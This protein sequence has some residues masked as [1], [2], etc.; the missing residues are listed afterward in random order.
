MAPVTKTKTWCSFAPLRHFKFFDISWWTPTGMIFIL[1]LLAQA[2]EAQGKPDAT[3]VSSNLLIRNNINKTDVFL[4][5]IFES[6]YQV[7]KASTWN[8]SQ[9]IMEGK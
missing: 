6:V 3:T 9:K 8:S 2:T 5:S 7:Q 4:F 1:K